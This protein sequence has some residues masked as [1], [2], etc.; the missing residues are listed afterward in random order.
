MI[1][2]YL[3]QTEG[4]IIVVM[5]SPEEA[6]RAVHEINGAPLYTKR[7]NITLYRDIGGYHELGGIKTMSTRDS[8]ALTW[9]WYASKSNSLKDIRLRYPRTTPPHGVFDAHRE[10]R[11]VAIIWDNRLPTQQVNKLTYGLLHTY[12]VLAVYVRMFYASTAEKSKLPMCEAE[13]SMCEVI[14]ATTEAAEFVCQT[15]DRTV[16]HGSKCRVCLR[17]PPTRILGG[18][19]EASHNRAH[20]Q[21]R[22]L[23]SA[24]GTNLEKV[25]NLSYRCSR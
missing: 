23:G 4:Y 25:T 15:Y 3:G 9:G 12:D 8:Y 11:S 20:Y 6:D 22:D 7:I 17:K 21:P 5:S 19:W 18:S 14:F 13:R 24:K 2:D 1:Y 16:L 10:S